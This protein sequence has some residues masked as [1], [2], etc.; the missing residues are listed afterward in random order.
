MNLWVIPNQNKDLNISKNLTR[1]EDFYMRKK[2]KEVGC[3]IDQARAVVSQN[4]SI[5]ILSSAEQ[6]CLYYALIEF[7]A[8]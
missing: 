5:Y 2:P 7:H 1:N 8:C 6:T 4:T 3:T